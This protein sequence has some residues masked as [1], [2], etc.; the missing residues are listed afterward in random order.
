MFSVFLSVRFYTRNFKVAIW[1]SFYIITKPCKIGWA[2]CV[3]YTE[4]PSNLFYLDRVTN[5]YHIWMG[6]GIF[7][8]ETSLYKGNV[9]NL[10]SIVGPIQP[11]SSSGITF[12]IS[13]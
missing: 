10:F 11:T 9:L 1:A 4:R 13:D 3:G 5:D 2:A 6:L 12:F 7:S 8:C